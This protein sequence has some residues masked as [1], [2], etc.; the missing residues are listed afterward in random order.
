MPSLYVVVKYGDLFRGEC[1]NL[2]VFSY[3]VDPDIKEVH[4][5]FLTNLSRIEAV[6]GWKDTIMESLFNEWLVKIKTKSELE[7]AIKRS[8]SPYSSLQFT[9][10]HASL[11]EDA[12]QLVKDMASIFLVE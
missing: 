5:K 12:E 8:N 1:L 9:P 10:P 2:G 3:N 7:D 4:S 6:F 11:D